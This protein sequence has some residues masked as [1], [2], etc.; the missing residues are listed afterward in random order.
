[1]RRVSTIDVAVAFLAVAWTVLYVTLSVLQYE[2]GHNASFDLA[3]YARSLWGIAHGVPFN[4]LRDQHSL[5]LHS[6]AILYLL[7]PLTKVV[8]PVCVLLTLQAISLGGA[9]L[10]LYTISKRRLGREPIAACV[11]LSY[12][13]YPVAANAAL[14][15]AHPKTLAM[16]PILCLLDGLDRAGRREGTVIVLTADHGQALG[17]GGAIG[18]GAAIANAINDALR[19]FGAEI[20]EIPATPRRVLQAIADAAG[21]AARRG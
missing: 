20:C 10:L 14:F 3:L 7:A 6:H 15:D 21:K 1:M 2:T 19:P 8:S 16:I 18:P 13:L 12:F 5:A 11:A 17:E 9:G 4:P